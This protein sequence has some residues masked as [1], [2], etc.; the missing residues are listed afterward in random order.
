MKKAA[1][2]FEGT[3]DFSSYMAAD[4]KIK[5]T[6]RTVYSSEI[7]EDNG[8]ITFRVSADGFLYNMV[9]IFVGTLIDVA[10]GRIAPEDVDKITLSCDR[11]CAGS[12]APPQGLFLNRVVY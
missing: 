9:R 7:F 6:V 4:S 2:L 1:K 5:D 8:V 3:K 11:R 10:Y 12:T